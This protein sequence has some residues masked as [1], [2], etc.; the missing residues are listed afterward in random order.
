MKVIA[1]G[2]IHGKD[3]WK[4]I[5]D[6]EKPD[7]VVFVGDYFDS[8]DIGPEK[9]ILNFQDIIQYK[10]DNPD[11]VV[12]LLGNHD[13]H[14]LPVARETYSGYQRFAAYQITP[15]IKEA[16]ELGILQ[17]CHLH[18]DFLFSHAGISKTWCEKW[19]IDLG[20]DFVEQINDLVKYQGKQFRFQGTDIY[21]NDVTQSP[22][23]IRPDA[24]RADALEGFNHVVGHTRV[25]SIDLKFW[26]GN[27]T[28]LIQIDALDQG[29][30]LS[31]TP[32]GIPQRNKI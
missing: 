19:G 25:D 11:S 4:R 17:I 32:G 23:W 29:E 21:G 1:L 20:I 7:K 12:T 22:I 27:S 14:Y 6:K 3:I 13:F 18:G 2:D 16:V 5:I 15:L 24:L 10:K 8:F 26:D 30:Y 28:F 31:I 9:Q